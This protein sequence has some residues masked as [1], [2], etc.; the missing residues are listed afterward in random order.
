MPILFLIVVIDLIGFGV[1]IPLLPFYAEY[2]QA[3][4]FQ[5][6]LLM[7]S[8][9][10]AQFV[11]A[12]FWGRLSDKIG[13]RP[14]LLMSIA[15]SAVAYTSLGFAETL[16]VLFAARIMGG[17]MAG[18][19]AAAFAYVADITTKET[20][21]KGMGIMGAAF[22]VGFIFGPALG[23]I[24][25]GADAATADFR[26]PSFVAAGLSAIACILGIFFLKESLSEDIRSR[27][28]AMTKVNRMR[29]LMTALRQ[30]GIGF[31]IMLSFLATLVFAGLEAIFAIWSLRQFDWGPQQIGYLFAFIGVIAAIIQGGFIGKLTARFG[32]ERLIVAGS[33]GLTIG[34]ALTPLVRTET[35]LIVA[36]AIA[37]LGFSVLSPTLNTAISIR[38]EADVQGGLFGVTRSATTLSRVFGPILAGAAFAVF[39]HNSPY[40]FGAAAMILVTGLSFYFLILRTQQN[41]PKNNPDNEG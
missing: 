1:I 26:T 17:F 9:S 31:L 12:A 33:L 19:L 6:G 27:Q 24:L 30:P 10:A 2:Y 5:I 37:S 15:G 23:G 20:R 35:E 22:S 16:T 38:G 14:V 41:G 36:M 4:P 39:G 7:A 25:A 34:L 21:A 29:A 28:K 3:S 32:T 11:A 18:N 13:R 40:F 8:Y